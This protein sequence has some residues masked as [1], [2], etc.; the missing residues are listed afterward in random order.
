MPSTQALRALFDS[1]AFM[2]AF[3]LLL[4]LFFELGFRLAMRQKTSPPYKGRPVESAIIGLLALLL[5]FTFNQ[6]GISYRERLAIVH[7]ESDTVAQVYRMSEMLPE[8][9]RRTLRNHLIDYL[10]AKAAMATDRE[11]IRIHSRIFRHVLNLMRQQT[12][13]EASGLTL[14]QSVNRMI[15]LHFRGVYSRSERVPVPVIGLLV[16]GSFSIGLMVGFASGC[17]ERRSWVI[18]LVFFIMVSGTLAVIRDLDDPYGGLIRVDFSNL[19]DLLEVLKRMR[20]SN[21]G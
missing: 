12:I 7:E 4:L 15:Q 8:A 9:E 2:P 18:P 19:L 1:I 10:E 6:A 17:N 11:V 5:G 14:V 21:P 16:I 3:C 20:L 13:T